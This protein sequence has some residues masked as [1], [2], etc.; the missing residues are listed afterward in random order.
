MQGEFLRAALAGRSVT[1]ARRNANRIARG[2]R[3]G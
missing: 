1:G 2:G 3:A